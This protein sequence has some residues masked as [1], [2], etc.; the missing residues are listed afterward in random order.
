MPNGD[1]APDPNTHSPPLQLPSAFEFLA[2][3]PPLSVYRTIWEAAGVR[4]INERLAEGWELIM[5]EFC[6]E[7]L[8][9]SP[10]SRVPTSTHY[11][12]YAIIGKRDPLVSTD[13]AALADSTERAAA[14]RAIPLDAEA[15]AGG[16]APAEDPPADMGPV[17]MGAAP[18]RPHRRTTPTA[19][20]EREG[21]TGTGALKGR[22]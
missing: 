1:E 2:P 20:A 16:S 18:R 22:G 4:Q 9:R 15:P 17:P 3:P 7:V 12:P 5:V 11:V 19:T 14:E 8:Q 13:R 6:E 21:F 10:T